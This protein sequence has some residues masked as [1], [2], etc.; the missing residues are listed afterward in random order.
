MRCL[1]GNNAYPAVR[2]ASPAACRSDSPSTATSPM[3]GTARYVCSSACVNEQ[4]AGVMT[5]T[6][7]AY[8][9]ESH[10]RRLCVAVT[11]VHGKHRHAAY[12]YYDVH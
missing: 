8:E 9:C 1:R 5:A 10:I 11:I 2:V 12:C 7:K 4:A 6:H 3:S